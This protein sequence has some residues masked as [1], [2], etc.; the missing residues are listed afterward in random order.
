MLVAKVFMTVF[1]KI[2]SNPEPRGNFIARLLTLILFSSK[3]E[4][5]ETRLTSLNFKLHITMCG[6]R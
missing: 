1:R 2:K 4:D 6:T 5:L 3:M